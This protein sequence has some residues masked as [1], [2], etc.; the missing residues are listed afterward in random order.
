MSFNPPKCKF[1]RVTNKRK[2][3]LQNYYIENTLIKEVSSATF[4]GVAIDS[5]LT[6]NNHIQR[7][8]NKA[9]QISAFLHRNLCHCPS[10]VKCN[11]CKSMVRPKAK[12]DSSLLDGSILFMCKGPRL[13][14][15]IPQLMSIQ[16]NLVFLICCVDLISLLGNY[17]L[18]CTLAWEALI[19]RTRCS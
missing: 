6:W 12:S 8:V 2:P 1:L 18:A 14:I 13:V 17:L 4:L 10:H 16:D 11:C 7:I 5:K 9:N 3:I 19:I 15:C